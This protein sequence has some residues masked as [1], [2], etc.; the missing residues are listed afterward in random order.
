MNLRDEILNRLYDIDSEKPLEE[1]LGPN[2]NLLLNFWGY[3]DSLSEIQRHEAEE[4]RRLRTETRF[5]YF[6]SLKRIS[7]FFGETI[8]LI[9]TGYE[10]TLR[11]TSFELYLIDKILDRGMNPLYIKLYEN[12]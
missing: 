6:Y 5:D 11:T 10:P 2:Y 8:D 9:T 3:Y 4:R 1:S 12:L 7:S